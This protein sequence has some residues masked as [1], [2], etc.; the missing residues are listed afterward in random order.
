MH[1]A[2]TTTTMTMQDPGEG[3]VTSGFETWL[4]PPILEPVAAPLFQLLPSATSASQQAAQPQFALPLPQTSS[5]LATNPS[6]LFQAT[7][8]TPVPWCL[9]SQVSETYDPLVNGPLEH[10]LAAFDF[11]VKLPSSAPSQEQLLKHF[12]LRRVFHSHVSSL[13]LSYPFTIPFN[14]LMSISLQSLRFIGHPI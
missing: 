5:S 9:T 10:A 11:C 12:L 7:S 2:S 1:P 14:E 8:Q 4:F 13:L 6:Q 3:L